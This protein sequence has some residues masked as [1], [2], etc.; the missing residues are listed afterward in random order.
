MLAL[1]L[2][3]CLLGVGAGLFAGSGVTVLTGRYL[4]ASGGSHIVIR[5]SERLRRRLPV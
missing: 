2:C 4:Q 3:I 5:R 1:V